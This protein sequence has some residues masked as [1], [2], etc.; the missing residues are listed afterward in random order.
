MRHEIATIQLLASVLHSAP[1]VGPESRQRAGQIL[2]ETRWL[3]QLQRAYEGTLSD[4][5]AAPGGDLDVIRLDVCAREVVTAAQLTTT[6]EIRYE[7]QETWA[8]V[9]RLA[10]WRALR[11][12]ISNAVRAAGPHGRID[13]RVHRA[14]GRSVVQVDDDGPGFGAGTPGLGAF[15]L[16]IVREFAVARGG[17]LEIG[18]GRLGGCL[19]ALRLPGAAPSRSAGT[20]GV[21]DAGP[22]L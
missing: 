14:A 4:V 21:G 13:V 2:H 10:I 6:T 1:D 17:E 5:D 22:G 16:D 8:R 9:D 19:V 7:C 20:V 15:G 18:S 12:M 3:E 11:N